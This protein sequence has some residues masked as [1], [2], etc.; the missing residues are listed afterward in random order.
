MITGVRGYLVNTGKWLGRPV[1]IKD[2]NKQEK[3]Y[4]YVTGFCIFARFVQGQIPK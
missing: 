1:N 3:I 2:A 4:V